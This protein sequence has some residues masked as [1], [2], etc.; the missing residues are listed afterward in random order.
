[1][2]AASA[3]VNIGASIG[4]TGLLGSPGPLLGSLVTGVI[5]IVFLNR[6]I[7][8]LATIN[9]LEYLREA[10]GRPALAAVPTLCVLAA[11][12]AV[13]IQRDVGLAAVAAIGGG[14][15]VACGFAFA[16]STAERD[17]LARRLHAL[18]RVR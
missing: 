3:I 13:G 12:H 7:A 6:R 16:L 17:L 15:Y 4:F 14:L 9:P 11:S 18:A 1:V 2:L 10:I 8:Q 5:S